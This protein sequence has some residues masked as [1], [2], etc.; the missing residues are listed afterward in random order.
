MKNKAL[1]SFF[2]SLIMVLAISS[3]SFAMRIL[4]VV[5]D[6][7]VTE[8]EFSKRMELVI[9]N[10]NLPEKKEVIESIKPQVIN[11]LIEEKLQLQEAERLGIEITPEEIQQ[12]IETIAQQNKMTA[13]QFQKL[14]RSQGIPLSSLAEQIKANIAWSR[15]VQQE[16]RPRIEITDADIDEQ[17]QRF[18]DAQ[19]KQEYLVSEIFLSTATEEQ[20]AQAR[21]LAKDLFAQLK[22]KKAQFGAVAQQF[23]QG[24]GAANGGLIGWVQEGQLPPEV[25]AA[26]QQMEKGS[27]SPPIETRNGYHIIW[28]QDKRV[29]QMSEESNELVLR[30]EIGN[31]LG[32]QR[33]EKMARRYLTDLR[34]A[35]F[36]EFRG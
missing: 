25:E 27:I 13:E 20:A 2:I 11:S 36:I 19:G 1:Y 35:A 3:Q 18:Y 28:L 12:G 15:V 14:M 5:N 31:N 4:A 24:A 26:A 10:S 34:S 8:V 21:A 7:V 6:D 29:I 9:K 16:I 23:S 22:A 17:L 30:T 33:L 32:M